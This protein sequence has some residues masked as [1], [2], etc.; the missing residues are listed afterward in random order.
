MT[1]QKLLKKA[2]DLDACNIIDGVRTY[3]EL[4][5]AYFSPQGQEFCEKNTFPLLEDIKPLQRKLEPFGV[6]INKGLVETTEHR[7][8][9]I[10]E[11]EGIVTAKGTEA[12]YCI[13]VQHGATLRVNASAYAVVSITNING[14]DIIINADETVVIL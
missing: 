2:K 6:Y 12:V 7:V 14:G 1:I 9:F 4:A 5:E 11:T 10:G 13:V 3:K 8:A